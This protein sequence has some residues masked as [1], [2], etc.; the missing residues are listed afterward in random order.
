MNFL[1]NRFQN[2]CIGMGS[3]EWPLKL[4]D[5]NSLDFWEYIKQ[6]VYAEEP[7]TAENMKNRIRE[8]CTNIN[9]DVLQKV[10]ND[11]RRRLD[12]CF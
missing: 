12:V 5:L 10:R 6:K 9:I 4:F 11:F 2:R 1:N 8:A 3:H 7:A